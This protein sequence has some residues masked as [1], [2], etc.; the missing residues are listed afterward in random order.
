MQSEIFSWHKTTQ[1]VSQ[2]KLVQTEVC[3]N[4]INKNAILCKH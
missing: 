2:I 3:F 4:N 1:Q